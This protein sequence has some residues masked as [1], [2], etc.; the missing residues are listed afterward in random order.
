MNQ[1]NLLKRWISGMQNLTPRQIAHAK[2]FSHGG[3]VFG[4]I[5]AAIVMLTKGLWYW[6][7][8]LFFVTIIQ[9]LEFL[10]TRQTYIQIT[11]IEKELKQYET[12]KN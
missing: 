5:L 12:K 7:P 9:F 10:G 1:N 8:F 11:Q 2:M 3:G 4:L 6:M